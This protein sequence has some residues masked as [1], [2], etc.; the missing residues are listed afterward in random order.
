M[1]ADRITAHPMDKKATLQKSSSQIGFRV[2][3]KNPSGSSAAVEAAKPKEKGKER[4]QPSAPNIEKPVEIP[5]QQSHYFAAKPKDKGKGRQLPSVLNVVKLVETLP[6]REYAQAAP[7]PVEV[8]PAA[9]SSKQTAQ[10]RPVSPEPEP[11]PPSQPY[12]TRKGPN[13][14]NDIEHSQF[15]PPSF[16][17]D[18]FQTTSTISNTHNSYPP[19]SPPTS[20]DPHLHPSAQSCRLSSAPSLHLSSLLPPLRAHHRSRRLRGDGIKR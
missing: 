6:P 4:R 1:S 20:S 9:S 12:V 7:A 11:E 13:H 3:K 15:L 19:P 8:L 10:A 2:V 16:P 17:S 18:L 14:I 5:P